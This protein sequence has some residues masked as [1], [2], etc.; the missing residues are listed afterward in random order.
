MYVVFQHSG[1]FRITTTQSKRHLFV[2]FLA[3]F[4]TQNLE[5]QTNGVNTPS[6]LTPTAAQ[7][8]SAPAT[9]LSVSPQEEI[10][11]LDVDL[12]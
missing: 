1:P 7:S 2:F 9:D 4:M 5:A 10:Q 12:H 8:A 11:I 3:I 6:S